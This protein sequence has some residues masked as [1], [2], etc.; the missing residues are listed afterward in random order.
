[1]LHVLEKGVEQGKRE[2]L[3]KACE[4][5]KEWDA[6]RVCIEGHKDWFIEQF[7]KAMEE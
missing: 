1:M 6:Y 2:M 5:L 3:D 4:W 7:R